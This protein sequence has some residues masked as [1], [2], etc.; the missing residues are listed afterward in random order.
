[1][2]KIFKIG[3]YTLFKRIRESNFG[4]V[5]LTLKENNPELLMTNVI[6]IS[7]KDIKSLLKYINNE[8][9]IMEELSHPNIIKLENFI[10]SKNH[11][12]F[13]M[14]YCNGGNLSDLL[15]KYKNKYRKPFPLEII[16]HFMHQIVEGL[17]YIHSLNIIHRNIKL[18]NIL[19]HFKNISR[20]TEKDGV[21]FDKLDDNDLLNS[22]IKIFDFGLSIKLESNELARSLVGT[23]FNMDPLILKKYQNYNGDKRAQGYN[24]KV[25]IWSLGTI[26]YQMLTGDPLFPVNTFDDLIQ[27]VEEGNYS[28]PIDIEI[29]NEIISFLNSMLQYN[30]DLRPSAEELLHHDF[31]KKNV[32]NFTKID[33]QKTPETKDKNYIILNFMRNPIYINNPKKPEN[34]KKVYLNYIDSLYNDYKKVKNYFKVNDLPERE[35]DANQKCLQIENIK[36]QFNSGKKI[37]LN[38][39]PKKIT[40]EYIYG[41]SIDERNKIYKAILSR[42]RAEKNA[43]EVKLKMFQANEISKN[44]K[45]EYEKNKVKFNRLKFIIE[46]LEEKSKN[47]WVPPPLY[48]KEIQKQKKR[49]ISFD[50]SEF[51]IKIKIKRIDKINDSLDLIVALIINQEWKL[52]KKLKL[53]GENYY[54][55]WFW[56]L[57]AEEWMNIDNNIS[58]FI[59][60]IEIDKFKCCYNYTNQ[61]INI[62]ISKLKN[63]KAITFNQQIDDN[64]IKLI[65]ISIL[66]IL[67]EGENTITIE[68]KE[69]LS[70]KKIYPPFEMKSINNNQIQKK[71]SQIKMSIKSQ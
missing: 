24:E 67:P 58:N 61:A 1:M 38:N 36:K 21:N 46:N 7:K 19:I 56:I 43:L 65:N 13:I 26:C 66:P 62:D 52:K 40:P 51:K 63:G 22:T 27:K 69:I 44:D 10:K 2:K 23:P 45:D 29:S 70:V 4:E 5:Y 14:E 39:L 42:Y 41:C 64:G 17:K 28:I 30:G 71:P 37:Y 6:D 47:I 34:S 32:K 54:D 57:Y 25:D 60:V 3:G 50:K 16:Q 20:N 59:L 33:F 53:K 18:S 8:K 15:I 11:Y 9:K 35:K 55:E 48:I 49:I 68:E 31:L 12:F